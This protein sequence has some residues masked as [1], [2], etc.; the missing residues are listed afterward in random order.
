[1]EDDL[2]FVI[3]EA[4]GQ[5]ISGGI[6]GVFKSHIKQTK[7]FEGFLPWPPK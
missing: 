2:I 7:F 6:F 5:I 3:I 1:M 4:E